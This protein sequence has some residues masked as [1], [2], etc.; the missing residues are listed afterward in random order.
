[1]VKP[2]YGVASSTSLEPHCLAGITF[3]QDKAIISS[4]DLS[5][6]VVQVYQATDDS[7]KGKAFDQ[8]GKDFA[9]IVDFANTMLTDYGACAV[10]KWKNP[11]KVYDPIDAIAETINFYV[12]A[13]GSVTPIWKLVAV[14]APLAPTFASAQRKDTNTLILSLGR[15]VISADGSVSASA[16]MNNQILASLLSQAV[17]Q[18]PFQ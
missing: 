8:A 17:A 11:P 4:V 3:N 12:T 9:K 6:H 10:K 15:P 5:S 1:L 14:T 2:L 18:R 13:S 16:A 7:S